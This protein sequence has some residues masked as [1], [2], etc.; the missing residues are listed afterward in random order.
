MVVEDWLAGDSH[1]RDTYIGGQ[2][3]PSR[4]EHLIS[5]VDPST[6]T[7]F[8]TVQES[9]ED[10]VDRAVAAAKS[11]L[12]TLA[13]LTVEDR[14][15]L[16]ESLA[17]ELEKRAD[18]L[19]ATITREMGMPVKYCADYQVRS[20]ISTVRGSAAS[21]SQ[22][23][24]EE[25]IAHSHV[26]REP[27]G[28]VAA[29]VPWNY[30]LLQTVSKLAPAFA[31]GCPV[32]LKPSEQAPL[33]ALILADALGAAGFPDGAV[34]LVF[35]TGPHIGE[36]LVRHPDVRMVSLTGSTRAGRRVSQ[37]A[38]STVKRVALELGGKSPAVILPDADLAAAVEHTVHS[39][40]VNSGQTC[41]ALTRLLVPFQELSTVEELVS[42]T[43]DRYRVGLPTDPNSDAGPLA[44]AH[45]HQQVVSH[46]ERAP[47][48][49]AKPV[50]R[51]R[52]VQVDG[53][54]FFVPLHA[55]TVTDPRI[56]L[57]QE[58]VFGPVLS[59]LPYVDEADAIEMANGTP[60]GLAATVWS[61]DEQHAMHVAAQIE[62]GT[63][64]I[65]GAPFNS[66]APFGGYKQSGNG[67]ELGV[68]GIL[69]FTETKSIQV[70]A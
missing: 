70:R 24:F 12:P 47:L 19:A 21:A 64:D 40:V 2:W 6:E 67:R 23:P 1:H 54:G 50:Y 68:H 13:A 32:V 55:F 53:G 57:A 16:L 39:V 44:N 45:Q 4:G 63:V 15:R 51:S 5:V 29:I 17:D 43:M 42:A 8:S 7:C 33:D 59:I 35:G 41:T 25:R 18:A 36:A 31:A 60:Y 34:N 49:G 22:V 10:D 20:S 58:E 62:S 61:A 11:A 69:E 28:I 37:V 65:N 30:P 46:L 9:S 48:D 3:E 66:A 56:R 38:A 27:M 26:R 14:V 52:D